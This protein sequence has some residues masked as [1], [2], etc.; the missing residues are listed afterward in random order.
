MAP[1]SAVAGE[2]RSVV[3]VPVKSFAAAKMRLAGVLSPAERAQLARHLAERVV[4]AAGRLPVAV[5]CDDDDVARWAKGAHARVIPEPGSGLNG[6]VSAA[7]RQLSM[8][9]YQR[10]VVAHSDL[11]LATDIS[12]LAR[13]EGIVLVPDRRLD[14][15]NV[16]SLPAGQAFR[17]SYGPGSFHRHQEEAR[18]SGLP[19]KVVCD[20]ALGWDVDVPA[21]M[22]AATF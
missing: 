8:E 14:G 9:G 2:S 4:R 15:T 1:V 3:L 10:V 12:W 11:A 19:W 13:E 18:R 16:I 7:Y 5:V 21:D 17:F 20:E 6:A 22:P